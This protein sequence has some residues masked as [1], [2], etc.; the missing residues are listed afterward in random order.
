M[1][2]ARFPKVRFQT[3]S[4]NW[5]VSHLQMHRNEFVVYGR[6]LLMILKI[7]QERQAVFAAGYGNQ[8][9]IPILDHAIFVDRLACAATY[10]SLQLSHYLSDLAESVGERHCPC[11]TQPVH[12]EPG[13]NSL[14]SKQSFNLIADC[15]RHL[16]CSH[17]R[18]IVS[19]LFKII[20]N[21][22]AFSN[23]IFNRPA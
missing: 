5:I 22:L 10:F 7:P 17:G 18:R 20:G 8:Y 2:E 9:T 1:G 21:M 11:I 15:V 16:R 13:N 19:I 23:D 6:A 3:L 4:A 12:A 14:P